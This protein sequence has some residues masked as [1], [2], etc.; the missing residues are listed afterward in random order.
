MVLELA[1]K[2]EIVLAFCLSPSVE[3]CTQDILEGQAAVEA[4]CDIA[5]PELDWILWIASGS[6]THFSL[7]ADCEANVGVLARRIA[8]VGVEETVALSD[9]SWSPLD[10]RSSPVTS[11]GESKAPFFAY[12]IGSQFWVQAHQC[13]NR[14]CKTLQSLIVLRPAQSVWLTRLLRCG[15]EPQEHLFLDA[16][17]NGDDISPLFVDSLDG[18]DLP[19]GKE[20]DDVL[21]ELRGCENIMAYR[22]W[23]Y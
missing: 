10:H 16:W 14:A 12:W 6:A 1:G 17:R 15:L 2:I 18:E 19:H 11:T 21:Q 22:A 23:F 13:E 5:D 9:R 4:C 3:G 7:E 20:G 8:D